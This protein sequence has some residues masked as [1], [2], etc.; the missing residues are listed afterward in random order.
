MTISSR[1]LRAAAG[2]T[3]QFIVAKS[4]NEAISKRQQTAFLCH[5]HKDHLLAKG[6]Q[7]LLNE[8]GWE[9]YIDW[10]D[11][12]LPSS[13]DKETA[14]KIKEK[15][16]QTDWFLFLATNHSTSSRWC[17]WEI[18]YADSVKSHE[19]IIMIPTLD[20]NGIWHGNEYLQLYKNIK[21]AS[22]NIINKS[23]Y[24]VFEPNTVKGGTW[25]EHL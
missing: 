17:P 18:G 22:N 4:L 1:E 6:L 9:V 21:D 12:E 25:I 3:R 24:A 13:P 15:I 16:E 11:E 5:S 20:D 7:N 19:K 10:L 8:N 14:A 23:G 2:R